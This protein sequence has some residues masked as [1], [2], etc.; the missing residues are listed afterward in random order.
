MC[1]VRAQTAT[2]VLDFLAVM[3]CSRTILECF[4]GANFLLSLV[5]GQIFVSFFIS[6]LI[7][8]LILFLDSFFVVGISFSNK[9]FFV[10]VSFHEL[11]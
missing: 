5:C 1:V 7:S 2:Q 3:V 4:A 8:F 6:F 9:K 10:S 11:D